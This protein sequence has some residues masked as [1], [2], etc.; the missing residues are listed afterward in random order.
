MAM[1][2]IKGMYFA[3]DEWLAKRHEEILE[4]DLPIIDAHHHLWEWGGRYMLPELLADIGQGHNILATVFV[5]CGS[6]YRQGVDPDLAS[7]GETEFA[8]GVA[9]CAASGVYGPTQVC[10]GI[11][12]TANLLLGDQVD[13]FLE[14][15]LARAGDRFK[16]IRYCSV[17]DADQTIRSTPIDFPPGLLMDAAFRSGFS[18]LERYGLSF[19][20]WLYHPQIPEFTDLARAFPGTTMI[21]DHIGAPLGIGVYAGKKDEVFA[22]WKSKMG[23]L[24]GCDNVHVK[25]GGLGLHLLGLDLDYE[26]LAEPASSEELAQ[27]WKP[28]IETVIELFGPNRCMFE[29]NS[30]VEKRAYSY[31]VLWNAFKHLA[32]SYSTDEKA[33]LFANS[34]AR[35]YR[36]GEFLS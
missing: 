23:Q 31:P 21:L 26:H 25:L 27:A 1:E 32:A 17:W 4:P 28:Y 5:Q 13:P 2:E 22:D 20:G 34:A 30:P 11:V 9:A 8:N 19:D 14:M 35:A 10:A 12:G 24:A 18:R 29:S 33:D 7:L 36:L 3:P 16:G 6:M 15:H